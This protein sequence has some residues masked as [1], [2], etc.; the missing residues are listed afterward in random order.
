MERTDNILVYGPSKPNSLSSTEAWLKPT[1]SLV[2]L[3]EKL[4]VD[5][6][7]GQLTCCGL[8]QESFSQEQWDPSKSVG[9]S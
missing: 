5:S 9:G 2:G 4:G 7:I 6:W 3:G 1:A 8:C